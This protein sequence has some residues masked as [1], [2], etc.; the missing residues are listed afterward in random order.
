MADQS[1]CYCD[2]SQARSVL[3][4]PSGQGIMIIPSGWQWGMVRSCARDPR[5]PTAEHHAKPVL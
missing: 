2:P 4:G 1:P 3:E 5:D